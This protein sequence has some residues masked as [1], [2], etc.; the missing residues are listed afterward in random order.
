ML[1]MVFP[2]TQSVLR[3][4][5]RSSLRFFH[6]ASLAIVSHV[7]T[8]NVRSRCVFFALSKTSVPSTLKAKPGA[9]R[10]FANRE[11]GY[12]IRD[13]RTWSQEQSGY[14]GNISSQTANL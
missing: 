1:K 11:A 2:F 9:D 12:S 10:R 5:R 4:V 6:L 7:A 8:G 3:Q 13:L 14:V